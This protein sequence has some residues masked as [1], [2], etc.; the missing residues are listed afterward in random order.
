MSWTPFRDRLS[1][2]PL[3]LAGPTLQHTASDTVT[4]WVALQESRWVELQVYATTDRGSVLGELVATGGRS[5]IR[6]GQHL[7]LI[8]ITAK[9]IGNLKLQP[10]QIYAYTLWFEGDM[11]LQQAL[12][13]P[14]LPKVSISYFSHQLP[15]FSLPPKDLDRLQII[16][17]SCRKMHGRFDDALPILD[18]LIE[19]SAGSADDRP[20][21]LF[22]TGDRIYGDDVAD[23]LLWVATELG[24]TLL[25]W[26][27]PLP[28]LPA[29]STNGEIETTPQ[30][31]KP[32]Q[33]SQIAEQQ[34]GFTAGLHGK[35]R[36]TKSHLFSFGEYCA[37]YLLAESEVFWTEPFPNRTEMG[38]TVQD[39][40]RWDKEL[41]HL[42]RFS[43]SLP[44]VRRAL[45]NIPTYS[46]FDDHDVSDDWFL[47]QVWCLQVLGKPLGR[48]VV[49]NAML[50]YAIFQGWGNTPEQFEEGKSGAKLLA[51]IRDW[52]KSGAVDAIASDR[53]RRYL[54]LP[55]TDTVTDLPKMRQEGSVLVLDRDPEALIWNYT[56]RSDCHEVIVLDTRTWRGYPIDGNAIAPPMLLCPTAIARQLRTALEETDRLNATGTS[57]I[58]ATIVVASTNLF[59]L[60]GIDWIQR[61]YLWRRQVFHRDVGDAWNLNPIARS[62][63]LATLFANREQVTILSGDVHYGSAARLE[64]WS[65]HDRSASFK[66]HIL[67]QLTSSSLKNTEFLT[68]LVHTKV[69]Q[70]IWPE[71]QRWWIGRTT[72]PEE[73]EVK[74]IEGKLPLSSPDWIMSLD[75][76]PRQS[77][78]M[79]PWMQGVSWLKSPRNSQSGWQK[80]IDLFWQSR[81]L[82]EGKDVVGLNNLGVVHWERSEDTDQSAIVQDLYWYA[83]WGEPQIV[84]SRFRIPL[85]RRPFL[86][87]LIHEPIQLMPKSGDRSAG[88]DPH[89]ESINLLKLTNGDN[90]LN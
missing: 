31:L 88:S 77:A 66:P 83:S 15:T 82:Q 30:H 85:H 64:Y 22:L 70:M 57:H 27:E 32:G 3:I 86:D 8:A 18:R 79:I 11:M 40:D 12:T 7:H 26:Q 54:G 36:N 56:I 39:A 48:R 2:L 87:N 62:Q 63:L 61:W 10:G 59:G 73:I 71:R 50:A 74:S 52:S 60:E 4:I 44:Q 13:S 6:I 80:F 25:G 90:L 23:A 72:P 43:Q 89:T 53:I 78:Q 81:W 67:A 42:E 75:W 14:L 68:Q 37:V 41:S 24:D 69:K 45:A 84:L 17:G 65:R 28:L 46:I 1:Q 55:D 76:M 19:H 16:H 5:T 20:H 9:S 33:R 51:A 49:Q 47:N 21:Q 34:A 29:A 38:S 35:S 58:K